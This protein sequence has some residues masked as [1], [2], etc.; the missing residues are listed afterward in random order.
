MFAIFAKWSSGRWLYMCLH[1]QIAL[2]YSYM[3]H[4]F[5]CLGVNVEFTDRSWWWRRWAILI[6]PPL[7]GDWFVVI[8]DPITISLLLCSQCQCV[9]DWGIP[10]LTLIQ[11]IQLQGH[12]L[13]EELSR[14][15]SICARGW[16]RNYW[17]F[18]LR[19]SSDAGS[20]SEL[21]TI[22]LHHRTD[23]ARSVV[24]LQQFALCLK[25]GLVCWSIR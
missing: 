6:H 8:I 11:S 10:G 19:P 18:A 25:F 12:K 16:G 15:N 21:S 23:V 7:H 20:W 9:K 2:R 3:A 22:S 17:C 5:L 1:H 24:F 14:S 13:L 4:G